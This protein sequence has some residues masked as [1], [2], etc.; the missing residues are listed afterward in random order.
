MQKND[1][2]PRGFV[3]KVRKIVKWL[4][5]EPHFVILTRKF[6]QE[7]ELHT[8]FLVKSQSVVRV[9]QAPTK[10]EKILID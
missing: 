5:L 3:A 4:N 8:I 10:Y 1:E 2:K 7:V 6:V 9:I